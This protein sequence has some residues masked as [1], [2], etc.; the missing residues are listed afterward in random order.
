MLSIS[1]A[2]CIHAY[3]QFSDLVNTDRDD[4]H[5]YLQLQ[6]CPACLEIARLLLLH[7]AHDWPLHPWMTFLSAENKY[8]SRHHIINNLTHTHSTNTPSYQLANK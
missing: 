4:I 8:L 5:L 1:S 3:I 6:F 7:R 2:N